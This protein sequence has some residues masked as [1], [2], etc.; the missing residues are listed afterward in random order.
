[1][2]PKWSDYQRQFAAWLRQPD[3]NHL[4][5]ET[6]SERMAVYRRLVFNNFQIF[7][8]SCF[9]LTRQIV[10]RAQ[11]QRLLEQSFTEMRPTSPLFRDIPATFLAWLQ[12]KATELMPQLPWL[13]EFMHYEWLELAAE[14]HPARLEE[15]LK[16]R[17][18]NREWPI[19]N[20][21]L[22]LGCYQW[23]VH[24]IQPNRLPTASATEPYCFAV[25]RNRAD[26]VTFIAINPI[27]LQLL[28]RL[29]AQQPLTQVLEQLCE[30]LGVPLNESLVQFAREFLDSMVAAEVVL[31]SGES[32]HSP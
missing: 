27:T 9:P 11:W 3:P 24:T 22:Q 8:D 1:M 29:A 20:P 17:D 25:I 28:Q 30:Q 18:A 21:T 6:D 13:W 16:Q 10:D 12:P 2:Q 7:V 5:P 15:P 32:R 4:P 14:I 26:E 31:V 19:I 23:P